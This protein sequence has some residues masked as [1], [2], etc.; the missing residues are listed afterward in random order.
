MALLSSSG[1]KSALPGYAS[2]IWGG[3]E[4]DT[5]WDRPGGPSTR[6]LRE[7][8]SR[9]GCRPPGPPRFPGLPAPVGWSGVAVAPR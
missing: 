2:R 9:G 4:L 6:I 7:W 8:P 5:P 1:V 3:E